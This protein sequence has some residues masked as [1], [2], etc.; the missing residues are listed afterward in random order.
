MRYAQTIADLCVI[1]AS[2][3]KP[4]SLGEER[5]AAIS[6]EIQSLR[7]PP[8]MDV[9]PA[10]GNWPVLE[11]A[12]RY[13]LNYARRTKRSLP[14]QSFTQFRSRIAARR[15]ATDFERASRTRGRARAATTPPSG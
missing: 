4:G 7:L 15:S 6:P 8:E 11:Q 13:T 12:V 14:P 3:V 9:L 10:P 2:D 1:V 5:L